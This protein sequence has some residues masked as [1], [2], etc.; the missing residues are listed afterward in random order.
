MGGKFLSLSCTYT[1]DG[2]K[3]ACAFLEQSAQMSIELKVV[4]R[5]ANVFRWN[6][7]VSCAL[8]YYLY[9]VSHHVTCMTQIHTKST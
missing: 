6:S 3:N 8:L 4:M 7:I 9:A 1:H 5:Y 2:K